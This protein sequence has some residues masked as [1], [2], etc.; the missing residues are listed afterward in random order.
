MTKRAKMAIIRTDFFIK[1]LRSDGLKYVKFVG[2][3]LLSTVMRRAS[4]LDV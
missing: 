2:R 4:E 1:A 3:K